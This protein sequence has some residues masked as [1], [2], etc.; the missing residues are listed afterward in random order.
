MSNKRMDSKGEF[1]NESARVAEAEIKGEELLPKVPT[2][3][4]EVVEAIEDGTIPEGEIL[5]KIRKLDCTRNV[6]E[7]I[8]R[9]SGNGETRFYMFP[10]DKISGIFMSDRLPKWWKCQKLEGNGRFGSTSASGAFIP[11]FIDFEPWAEGLDH[12]ECEFLKESYHA[13]GMNSSNLSEWEEVRRD[14]EKMFVRRPDLAKT[15]HD[16]FGNNALHYCFAN[17]VEMDGAGEPYGEWSDG[18][19]RLAAFLVEN[20]CDPNEPNDFGVRF[21]DLHTCPWR[22]G[23]FR[24]WTK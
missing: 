7:L 2:T 19:E 5:R 3:I 4:A 21:C 15:T 17:F 14:F 13:S 20:G 6:E 23:L 16:M 8:C 18:T 9:C 10:Q 11:T 12:D 22:E 24:T 1:R